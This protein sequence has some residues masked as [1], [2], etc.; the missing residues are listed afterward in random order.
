[1][2]IK[3]LAAFFSAGLA[4][5]C[6][7]VPPALADEWNKKT[8]FTF[9]EPVEVPGHVLMP[10]KYV[11]ELADLSS[12]RN[13]VQI[14]SEDKN[15]VDHLVT[16]AMAVGAYQWNTPDKPEVTFEERHTNSPEAVHKWFYPGDNYGWEF[17]YPRAE[18]LVASNTT[19]AP[20]AT[21]V[22]SAAPAP[23]AP[24]TA[25]P[26]QRVA[27][28]PARKPTP[29]AVV[30]QNQA[31]PPPSKPPATSPTLPKTASNLPLTT[32]LGALFMALGLGLLAGRRREG[33][34]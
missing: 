3:L 30:A 15:G 5:L 32:G 11:F 2:N 17:V 16:T 33:A 18:R 28:A 1:M 20:R 22:Q 6:Y 25:P 4:T 24:V 21:P 10:G 7:W 23:K 12:D 9:D 19:P 29:S 27:A 34:R 14:F 26:P 13:V 31:P 8:I